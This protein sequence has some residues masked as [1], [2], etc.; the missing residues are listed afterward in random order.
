MS[1][2]A[3]NFT[4]NVMPHHLITKIKRA[5]RFLATPLREQAA[6]F[7][8]F[9]GI[10]GCCCWGFLF[11]NLDEWHHVSA[12]LRWIGVSAFVSYCPTCVVYACRGAWRVAAKWLF[13]VV[14]FVLMGTYAFLWNNFEMGISPH[15]ATLLAETSEGEAREFVQTYYNTQGTLIAA[16]CVAVALVIVV[17]LEWQ[18]REL[19]SVLYHKWARRL[20]VLPLLVALGTGAVTSYVFVQLATARASA[21]MDKWER[22][23]DPDGA[24]L[25]T[26]VIYS[27]HYLRTSGN[28]IVLATAQARAAQY[29]SCTTSE[30]DSLDVVFILGESYNKHHAS[31]YGYPLKTTPFLEGERDAGNLYVFTDVVAP[32]NATSVVQKNVFSCNSMVDGEYWY[33]RPTFPTVFR[34]AGFNVYFWDMQRNYS[35]HK[36]FTMTVNDFLYNKEI[37]RLSYTDTVSCSFAFDGQ[38]VGDYVAHHTPPSLHNLVIFHFMGQH[39]AA[40]SRYPSSFAHFT[41]DSIRR[42]AP[43]LTRDKKGYIAHY[44]NATLY[45]DAVVKAVFDLYRHR[46]AVVVYFADHGD[47]VYDYRDVK[48]RHGHYEPDSLHLKYQI[49]VPFM[50]WCSDRYKELHPDIVSRIEAA[51]DRPFMLDNA[52]QLFFDV[53]RLESPY[54]RPERDPLSPS[55]A[56][57]RRIVYYRY[58]YDERRHPKP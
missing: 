32:Y 33:D 54:Y 21:E 52:C 4:K 38:L 27:L 5:L 2:F 50:V 18:R 15:T 8:S 22:D 10:T 42:D 40:H 19:A 26:S 12:T 58:D 31:L 34:R 41:A 1:N 3:P 56:P 43:W 29:A 9:M 14:A 11:G 57:T 6:F 47:E 16:I 35:P 23:H 37:S 13:Y 30:P 48:G 53:A 28:D 24:D 51:L 17:A 46:N 20:V 36:L 44:D 55:F 39:V 49:E 7:L 45:N 25:V